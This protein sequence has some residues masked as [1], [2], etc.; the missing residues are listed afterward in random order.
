MVLHPAGRIFGALPAVAV[1]SLLGAVQTQSSWWHHRWCC[2]LL[3]GSSALF[4]LLLFCHCSVQ[5]SG[6]LLI[7]AT[8]VVAP[9][10]PCHSVQVAL[11]LSP[12]GISQAEFGGY[13]PRGLPYH[14]LEWGY[15]FKRRE[16]VVPLLR[17]RQ[18][19][20]VC[21]VLR[22]LLARSLISAAVLLC[23]LVAERQLL[24]VPTPGAVPR[25]SPCSFR[26]A[27]RR[28][29]TLL[30][31]RVSPYKPRHPVW[32]LGHPRAVAI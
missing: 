25:A 7:G 17:C 28:H 23:P 18:A 29:C 6:S 10:L 1:L 11:Y 3:A 24:Q 21:V 8:V 27:L 30:L 14:G 9:R 22:A 31:Q 2:T 12:H 26:Q 19:V 20:P 15:I 4:L 16:A 5:L 13:V 32:S